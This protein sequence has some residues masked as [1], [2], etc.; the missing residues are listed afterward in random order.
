MNKTKTYEIT[1]IDADGRKFGH[2]AAIPALPRFLHLC[3]EVLEMSDSDEPDTPAVHID[4]FARIGSSVWVNDDKFAL[5]V[6]T[7]G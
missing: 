3:D 5:Y 7:T 4:T 2:I 6:R 1:L